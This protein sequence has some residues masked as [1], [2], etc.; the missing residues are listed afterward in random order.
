MSMTRQ[1]QLDAVVRNY[2]KW[3]EKNDMQFAVWK[4]GPATFDGKVKFLQTPCREIDSFG[5]ICHV[6]SRSEVEARKAKLQNKPVKWPEFV[7]LIVQDQDG[8]WFYGSYKDA[9]I[10]D[11][12]WAGVGEGMFYLAWKGEVIGDWRDTLEKRPEQEVKPEECEKTSSIELKEVPFESAL[13]TDLKCYKPVKLTK[14]SDK[15]EG[16]ISD[17]YHKPD[18]VLSDAK[19]EEVRN[20]DSGSVT[21]EGGK[22]NGEGLPPVGVECYLQLAFNDMGECLITY[23]GDGVFCYRQNSS[24]NEYTGSVRDTV[25]RSIKSDR[26]KWID[27]ALHVE[28]ELQDNYQPH[29]LIEALYDAGLGKLSES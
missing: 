7:N 18:Y 21:D 6:F 26:E 23:M 3:P 5:D 11:G 8:D 16:V 9:I 29:E 28:A 25:F 17:S 12:G 4:I 27:A 24:G 15:V 1:E 2:F 14:G 22:W 10:S 19:K 20:I 13:N